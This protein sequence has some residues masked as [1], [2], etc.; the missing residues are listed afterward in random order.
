LFHLGGAA[1][2]AAMPEHETLS[3]T[4]TSAAAILMAGGAPASPA[5][6]SLSV[7]LCGGSGSLGR[8]I[9][10]RLDASTARR[11]SQASARAEH[12][13][14]GPAMRENVWALWTP[15][16]AFGTATAAFGALGML[17]APVLA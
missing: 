1:L 3:A 11:A 12:G 5:L 16:L 4:S 10:R 6:W 9:E 17:L 8:M 14:L 13:H 15:F 2:G 7:L